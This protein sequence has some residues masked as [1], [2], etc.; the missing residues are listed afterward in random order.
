[1]TGV[2]PTPGS[3]LAGLAVGPVTAML[4]TPLGH[5]AMSLQGSASVCRAL[6][7]E[8]AASARSSSGETPMWNAEPVT[9][10]PGALRHHSV[11]SPQASVSV[12]RAWRVLA[13]TSAP[14]DTRGSSLTAHPATSA[15]LSGM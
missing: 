6:E 3:W 14:E 12:W 2:R 7:A 13:V 4:H 8:P 9:V 11:T 5:P 1:M 15:L 10:I